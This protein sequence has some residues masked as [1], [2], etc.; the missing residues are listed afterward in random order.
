MVKGHEVTVCGIE[1]TRKGETKEERW[2]R[3]FK[4]HDVF[5]TS[6]FSDPMEASAL[7]YTRDKLNKK[8]ILDCDD[9]FLDVH[10]S[11]PLYD[12]LKATKRDKAF[13]ATILSLA[14]VITVSTEPLRQKLYDHFKKVHGLEKK[15]VVIPNMNDLADW[16]F[17]PTPKHKDKF[18]VGYAGSNS[19]Q[20]D[21]E[22]FL[23]ELLKI[24]RKYP[25]VYFESVGSISKDML[26]MF[27]EFDFPIMERCDLL[28]ST[29]TFKQYP[30]MLAAQKWNIGVAPLVDSAFTRCKSHIKFL[31]YSAIKLPVIA[32]KVHPYYVE[33]EGKEVITHDKTGLLVKPSEWFDAME[34]LILN[35]DKRI[36]IGKSAYEHVKNNWQYK[37]SNLSEKISEMLNDL[38]VA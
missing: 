30:E 18:I 22:M 3:I 14:D 28:P 5:W 32:S 17:P 13:M 8:V 12:K 2:A 23:P 7:F 36:K 25:H 29:W 26:H 19:H 9:N 24:M 33:V 27:K 35:E 21:L 6:Y 4:D 10:P 31:E 15:I 38:N 11:H 34:E 20:D 16:D 37:T 1:L